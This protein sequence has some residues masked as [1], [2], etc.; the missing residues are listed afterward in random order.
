MKMIKTFIK[1]NQKIMEFLRFGIV[2][3]IST[4]ITY[5]V[6]YI[7]CY[8]INPTISYTIGYIISFI[9]NFILTTYFTFEVKPSVKKG[10]GFGFSHIVNYLLSI[11]LL[12]LFLYIGVSEKL[13]PIPVFAICIPTNFLMVRFFVKKK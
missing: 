6:Y 3:A 1:E 10:F 8:W 5:G 7:C 4:V 12:N 9:C 11:G 2:G 13:A